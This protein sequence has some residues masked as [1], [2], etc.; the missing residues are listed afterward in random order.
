MHAERYGT[1]LRGL[2]AN[3]RGHAYVTYLNVPFEDTVARRQ[4]QEFTPEDMRGWC[5]IT[6][7]LDRRPH[8]QAPSCRPETAGCAGIGL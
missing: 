1:M 3:H 5:A 6:C 8:H 2:I 4:A 7:R